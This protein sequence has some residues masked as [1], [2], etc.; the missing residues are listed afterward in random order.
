MTLVLN[1]SVGVSDVDGS[2]A[3]PAIRGTD[4]NTGMFF[5]AADTIAFATA[6]TEDFRIG[7]AGELGIQGANYGTSGQ[8]LTSGGSGAAPTWTTPSG[9]ATGTI[10]G[11]GSSSPPSGFLACDGSTYNDASYTALAAVLG[12]IRS[13]VYTNNYAST[14]QIGDG[15]GFANSR[16]FLLRDNSATASYFSADSGATWSSTTSP[17]GGNI[18]WTGTYYVAGHCIDCSGSAG[19]F[20]ST[21]A[22]SWTRVTTNIN[23]TV[24]GIAWSG[25]RLVAVG[26]NVASNS[27]STNQGLNWTAGG[28]IGF[29][30]YDVTFGASLFV[31]VGVSGSAGRI[32]TSTDGT[33]WTSRTLPSGF[34]TSVPIISV[35][36]VN[37]RFVA[38]DQN[39]NVASSTDGIT[40]TLDFSTG[41]RLA[42]PF[43]AASAGIRNRV[44]YN[45]ADSSYY[46]LGCY[47]TNLSSWFQV[48]KAASYGPVVGSTIMNVVVSDG[49]RLYNASG[50]IYNP[51]P[52]T[53][54]TQFLV[55][56]LTTNV[57]A[58]V[59]YHIKT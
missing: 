20:Y 59:F 52:Y 7:S 11:Y 33:S 14:L 34:A 22:T 46:L 26:Q 40:W 27:Y 12:N 44:A 55:P 16:V 18:V 41:N 43:A 56:N 28:A 42:S 39:C 50:T 23:Y 30:T 6:G 47:S 57:S 15:T 2:A 17:L 8:V 53:T 45:T 49:T 51:I 5:P 35:N 37:S 31:A 24:S 38:V 19:I 21:N 13:N 10:I 4:A 54:S 25:S 3:T 36:F 32:S 9:T 29:N 58:G 48:P 1:G